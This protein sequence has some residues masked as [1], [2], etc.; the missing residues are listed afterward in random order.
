MMRE[1]DLTIASKAEDHLHNVESILKR[2]KIVRHM[3]EFVHYLPTRIVFGTG[4]LDK[5]G[6]VAKK[7]GDK[8]MLVTGRHFARRYG[9]IDRFVRLLDEVGVKTVVFDRVEPNPSYETVNLGVE[10][11]RKERIELVIAFG[12]GSAMDAGKAISAL[13][14][15]GGKAEEHVYPKVIEEE[16]LPIIAMPTTCGTGSEVTKYAVL[17]DTRRKRKTVMVGEP[18]IP[19]VAIIDPTVLKHLPQR[20]VAWTAMDALSHAIEALCSRRST[21]LSDLLALEAIRLIFEN[22]ASAYKG[23]FDALVRLHY[24]SML[25]GMAINS[26]GTTIVHAMG[27]FLTTYH[28]VHHGL[29]NALLLPFAIDYNA[30][31]IEEKMVRLAGELGI[32]AREVQEVKRAIIL[33]LCNLQDQVNIPGNIKEVGVREEELNLMVEETL[34]YRRNLENNPREVKEGDVKEL[35]RK[36]LKGR[37]ALLP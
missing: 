6:E 29:A 21:P 8:A 7:Y 5:V 26:A 33:K 1:V 22:L 23:N 20:L 13:T 4:S 9:Y 12:G 31:Y 28:D 30:E 32:A 10:V 18:L 14:V 25:A 19:R 34:A 37:R 16:V 36:A 24:A 35:W 11:A 15:L 27:Y 3:R 2:V 17:T